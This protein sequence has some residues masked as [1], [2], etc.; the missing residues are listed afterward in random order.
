MLYLQ[1]VILIGGDQSTAVIALDIHLSLL[2]SPEV[3]PS[4]VKWLTLPS[5]PY[6]Q[7][8]SS[9]GVINDMI[10]TYGNELQCGNSFPTRY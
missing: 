8:L 1:Y 7:Y 3:T 4:S 2:I 6:P 5:L 9:A 10:V